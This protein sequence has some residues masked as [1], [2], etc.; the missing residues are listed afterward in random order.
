VTATERQRVSKVFQVA[1]RLPP[2]DRDAFV[3]R[4]CAGDPAFI[5]EVHL[6]FQRHEQINGRP[7][8]ERIGRYRITA[9]IGLGAFGQV[10]SALDPVVGR[11]VAIK[12]MNHP[13][14][15]DL[16]RRFH[17]E[18]RTAANLHHKNIVTVH[19]FGEEN[20]M[21]YLVMEFLDGTT[22]ESLIRDESVSLREK[23]EIMSEV[24]EGL[25]YAHRNGVT[26]RDVKPAN[27]M[28]LADGAVKIMD[29]GI[30]RLAAESATRLTRTGFVVGSPLYMAPEQFTGTSDA[31]SDIFGY[32]VTSYE[33]LTGRNPFEAPDPA[34]VM[35]RITNYEVPPLRASMPG[36]PEELEA[37][38]RRALAKS[39]QQRYNSMADV[40][41]DIRPVLLDL[42]RGEAQASYAEAE[43]LLHSG[44]LEAAKTAVR[45]ILKLDPGHAGARSLRQQVEEALR[46][47]EETDRAGA[48]LDRA[49]R[50][51][52]DRDYKQCAEAIAGLS[53]AGLPDPGLQLRLREIRE[54]LERAR[55]WRGLLDAARENLRAQNLT[56]ALQAVSEV[57]AE[58]PGNREG[59][60]LFEEVGEQIRARDKLRRLAEEIKCIEQLLA[61]GAIDPAMARLRQA[62][63]QHAGAPELSALRARAEARKARQER[64]RQLA[65]GLAEVRTLL[66]WQEI[67]R[68]LAVLGTLLGEFPDNVELQELHKYASERLAANRRQA[69]LSDLLAEVS[70]VLAKQDY[71]RAMLRLEA[72]I[73]E[74]GDEPGLTKLLQSAVAGRAAQKKERDIAQSLDE[75]NRFIESRQ[76]DQ[77]RGVLERALGDAADDP[78]LSALLTRVSSLETPRRQEPAGWTGQARGQFLELVRA[79]KWH[80][81]TAMVN[82]GL[83]R[84]PGDPALLTDQETLATYIANQERERAILYAIRRAESIGESGRLAEAA[85]ILEAAVRDHGKDGRLDEARARILESKPASYA[86]P[87]NTPRTGFL[88]ALRERARES[89]ALWIAPLALLLTGGTFW[90]IIGPVKTPKQSDTAASPA[91][92]LTIEFASEWHKVTQGEPW[93][94]DVR[95]KGGFRPF[96]WSISQGELPPGLILDSRLGMIRGTPTGAGSYTFMIRVSD[97]SGQSAGKVSTIE[98]GAAAK[99]AGQPKASAEAHNLTSVLKAITRPPP[100]RTKTGSQPPVPAPCGTPPFRLDQ[101]G[102]TRNGEVIWNGTLGNNQTL[103]I[104]GGHPSTGQLGGDVIPK[105]IPVRLAVPSTVSVVTAPS[106]ANC[107]SPHIVLRNDGTAKSEIRIKWEVYQP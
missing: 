6:L 15:A 89:P 100:A 69:R 94:Q 102:D 3:V 53:E 34:A 14:D 27:I 88:S 107:W 81:A 37:I 67:D 4:E 22:L 101:W 70:A 39:R 29:F 90:S 74:F 51:L 8:L 47:K 31:L 86:A 52:A 17:L 97:A 92:P 33:L 59:A 82:E 43:Q 38:L 10:Y 28:R 2:E 78:R 72:A 13:G 103:D 68:A 35:Y 65:A 48:Q 71:E 87:S 54:G 75:A 85:A 36:C 12:I 1:L 40:L 61:T 56:E 60:S 32:G 23:I 25:D 104:Q 7:A 50:A 9:A 95:V 98:V 24:A 20:R 46:R 91:N 19:E 49:L 105:G 16:A 30:A 66:T 79:A 55:K 26:H 83:R 80:E 99:P 77:A 57:V 42:R 106:A 76:I 41:A 64:E 96:R 58:D 73:A 11:Y 44:Q 21:P 62:E 5:R 84:F 45:V 63:E 18:A 93:V